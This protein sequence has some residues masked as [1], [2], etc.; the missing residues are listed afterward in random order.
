MIMAAAAELFHARGFRATRL[1]DI[2][3]AV[4][5][6]GPA[7]YRHFESKEALLGELLDRYTTRAT[8]DMQ[9]SLAKGTPREVLALLLRSAVT[10]AVEDGPLVAIAQSEF[11]HLP[12]S[13]R[14]GVRRRFD[15]IIDRWV[16]GILAVRKD[17]DA[18]EARVVAIG[19]VAMVRAGAQERVRSKDKLIDRL[20]RMATAA[21][22]AR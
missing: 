20:T 22:T 10:Q 15:T 7:V 11:A 6:T 21:I 12:A 8:R 5:M 1:E 17:L 3:A 2:G 9:V 19:V 4:G 18:E 14:R 16:A 13:K